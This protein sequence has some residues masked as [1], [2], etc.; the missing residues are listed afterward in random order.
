MLISNNYL[1]TYQQQLQSYPHFFPQSTKYVFNN[2]FLAQLK[3]EIHLSTLSTTRT[4]ISYM[5]NN[6]ERKNT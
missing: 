6:I 4:T 3:Q 2:R 5:I 1:S